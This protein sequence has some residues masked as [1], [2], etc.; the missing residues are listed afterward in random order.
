LIIKEPALK[1]AF[2]GNRFH[3]LM[4]IAL[5]R[6]DPD[7]LAGRVAAKYDSGKQDE[8]YGLLMDPEN[9]Y[10]TDE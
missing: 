4:R 7:F 8:I 6:G 3:N 9:W 2:E 5:R 1:T 10:L